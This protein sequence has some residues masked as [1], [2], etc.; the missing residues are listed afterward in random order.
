MLLGFILFAVLVLG[1]ALCVLALLLLGAAL[2]AQLLALIL[3]AAGASALASTAGALQ[4]L[5][6]AAFAFG[7][8]L[9]IVGALS[10]LFP[11]VRAFL[12]GLRLLLRIAMHGLLIEGLPGIL[13]TAATA[14]ETGGNVLAGPR[15]GPAEGS[16]SDGLT[17]AGQKLIAASAA[18]PQVKTVAPAREALWLRFNNA[19]HRTQGYVP[20][21]AGAPDDATIVTNV[22][23]GDAPISTLTS[24]L[25]QSGG[26]VQ[27]LGT[28]AANTGH[29]LQ[30]SASALR[31]A[32]T[33]I[34]QATQ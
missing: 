34:E 26:F 30:D 24:A 2:G 28:G 4:L 9:V 3:A 11:A 15:D 22:V 8:V 31:E 10:L 7:I 14:L 5:A 12:D 21:P 17:K 13:R 6:A 16:V 33:L 23:V 18:V 27:G 29:A 32:A 19:G 25:D 1:A 20:Q